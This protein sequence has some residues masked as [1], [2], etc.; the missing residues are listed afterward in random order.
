MPFWVCARPWTLLHLR[1]QPRLYRILL[2]IARD[3]VPLIL[4]SHPMIVGFALPE[5]LSCASQQPIRLPRRK[6]LERLKELAR[7]YQRK[8]K[9]VDMVCHDRKRSKLIVTEFPAFEE[10]IDDPLSD[11]VLLEEHGP[12]AS[13]VQVPIHPNEGLAS[14][15]F[16]GRREPRPRQAAMQVPGDEQPAPLRVDMGKA[17]L[18]IHLTISAIWSG[19]I[20]VAHALLRAVFLRLR[21]QGLG[22]LHGVHTSVNAARTSAYA[23]I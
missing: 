22:R 1:N 9:H 15:T 23:T 18:D 21:T 11:R 13:L 10:R 19:K 6:S 14:V 7:R 16:G 5:R 3:P 20:S 4:I 8:E 2:D 17:P 12:G